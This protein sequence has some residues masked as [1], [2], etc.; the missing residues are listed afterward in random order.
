MKRGIVFLVVCLPVS[1]FA[2]D[3]HSPDGSVVTLHSL[4]AEMTDRSSLASNRGPAYRLYHSSSWDRAELDGPDSK[5]WFGNKDYDNY[6]R[7]EDHGGRKEYVIMEARGAGAITKWWIPSTPFLNDRT[8]RIYLDDN[9]VPVIEENYTAFI[10][11]NAFV[12]WPFAFISS[13]EKSARFQY[14][15]PVGHPK[16]VGSDLYLPIPFAKSCKVTLDDSVFYYALDYR[17]YEEGT[18]VLS[19]SMAD[20][21]KNLGSVRAAGQ[22]LLAANTIA[23]PLIKSA[24]IGKDQS[25]ELDLPAGAHAIDGIYLKI[26]SRGDRQM[27]RAVVLQVI[28]DDQQTV[29]SPVAE[30]FGGGVY[31]R[32]VKNRNTEVRADGWMISDWVMPYRKS[33]KVIIRNYGGKPVAVELRARLKCSNGVIIPCIFMRAGMRKRH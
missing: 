14:G 32:P 3:R 23:A 10:N 25:V 15:L 1:G 8:V 19:F 29:W 6:I 26:D 5:G 28:A 33:A 7:A 11:G 12:K 22:A 24:T 18:K 30:F 20:Y 17:L 4:L 13:D 16:Q 21:E 2:Q 31:A 27:N 9:P